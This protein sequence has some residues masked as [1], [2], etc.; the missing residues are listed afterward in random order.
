MNF[1]KVKKIGLVTI[2]IGIMLCGFKQ[3]KIEENRIGKEEI[4]NE[5]DEIYQYENIYSM[6]IAESDFKLIISQNPIDIA[7]STENITSSTEERIRLAC[8]Y[9]DAW[10][11]QIELTLDVLKKSLLNQDYLVIEK[12]YEAWKEYVDNTVYVEQS[13]FYVGGHYGIGDSLTYPQVMECVAVKTRS[14][15]IELLSLEYA[16]NGKVKFIEYVG[17]D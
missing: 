7:F 11:M 2:L 10:N 6:I 5:C 8:K 4:H 1:S 12:S 14:Y 17:E 15:A 3:T 16:V 13:M 9:R